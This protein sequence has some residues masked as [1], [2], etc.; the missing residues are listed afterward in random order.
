MTNSDN[1]SLGKKL[2]NAAIFGSVGGA[3]VAFNKTF[4]HSVF[5]DNPK[6]FVQSSKT[7][8][9]KA[10]GSGIIA[11]MAYTGTKHI[12]EQSRG[13]QDYLNNTVGSVVT[14]FCL[15]AFTNS[16]KVGIRSGLLLIPLTIL[17]D[18]YNTEMNE[19]KEL[20]DSRFDSKGKEKLVIHN[21]MEE[22]NSQN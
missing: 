14:A 5:V 11:C 6:A 18:I 8:Y 2:F 12:L 16:L 15:G 1:P 7:L 17:S 4:S 13:T 19:S 21:K 9:G 10:V 22:L 3:V 20:L